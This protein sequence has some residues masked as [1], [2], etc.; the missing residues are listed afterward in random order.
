MAKT[1]FE[2]EFSLTPEENK[3]IIDKYH[4]IKWDKASEIVFGDKCG[5]VPKLYTTIYLKSQNLSQKI[6][7]DTGCDGYNNPYSQQANQ[8]KEFIVLIE[9]I[10]NLKNE[11]R[12]AP[13]SD[14]LY[15]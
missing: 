4:S 13:K 14:I 5:S 12:H 3:K 15:Y 7:I 10:I 9:N 8:L 2:T 1:P 11:I 6:Q